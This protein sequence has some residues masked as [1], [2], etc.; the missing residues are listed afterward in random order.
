MAEMD[1]RRNR[2]GATCGI[3]IGL[4]YRMDGFRRAPMLNC[5]MVM[6]CSARMVQSSN[7]PAKFDVLYHAN[8]T[9]GIV[10]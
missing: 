5:I 9:S 10:A 4:A 3:W 6:Q 2:D 1:V 7:A 8:Q